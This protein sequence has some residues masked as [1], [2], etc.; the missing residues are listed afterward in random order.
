[1]KQSFNQQEKRHVE[2]LW[3]VNKNNINPI[4]INVVH[5]EIYA[6]MKVILTRKYC[7]VT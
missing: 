1:M 7:L 6:T 3:E 4:P 5:A 2:L